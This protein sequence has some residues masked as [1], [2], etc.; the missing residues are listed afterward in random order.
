MLDLI[1]L[2][3]FIIIFLRSLKGYYNET[4]CNV[5]MVIGIIAAVAGIFLYY[6]ANQ[7]NSNRMIFLNTLVLGIAIAQRYVARYF[8]RLYN[9]K[10]EQSRQNLEREIEMRSRKR[11]GSDYQI[12]EADFDNEE[13]RFGK[14]GFKPYDED[15]TADDITLGD[16]K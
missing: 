3:L 8:A 12:A 7:G 4:L 6:F 14:G 10:V 11:D 16:K 9:E 5:A 15:Y 13:I 2:V 1:F